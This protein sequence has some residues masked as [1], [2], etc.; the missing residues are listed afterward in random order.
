MLKIT[1]SSRS[2]LFLL[3]F[4]VSEPEQPPG[5]T[6]NNIQTYQVFCL[7][8]LV[9]TPELL[10]TSHIAPTAESLH[11]LIIGLIL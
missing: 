3:D 11:L 5:C 6:L 8:D 7:W 9:A 1:S 4:S 2:G 10:N